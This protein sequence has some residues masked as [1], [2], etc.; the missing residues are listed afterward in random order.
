MFRF[1]L[2]IFFTFAFCAQVFSQADIT[3]RLYDKM[4]DSNPNDYIKT[5]VMLKDQVDLERLDKQLYEEKVLPA[6]RSQI[7]IR[8]L[9]DKAEKTQSQLIE[10]FTQKS[11]EGKVFSFRSFWIANMFAIEAKREVISELAANPDVELL[12][13]DDELD[14]DRPYDVSPANSDNSMASEPGLNIIKANQLW[15]LGYTGA[16][17]LVMHI[18][19]G[20]NINHAALSS[21]WRGNNGAQ[22]YHAWFD[23]ISPTSSLPF[24]CGSHGTHT[25][26]IMCGMVPGDT[27]GVAPDAQWIS[28][29]IT[30]CPGANYPSMNIAA[31]QWAMN[32]DSNISTTNDVPDVISC[33]WQDPNSN[34]QCSS[35]YVQTMN[36]LE[37]AGIG[38]VFS[39]GNSGPGA[40]TITPPKNIN[41]DEVNI[42]CVGNING[43]SYLGGNNNPIS[44]GSSRGPSTCGGVG[45]LLIKPE[46]VAPGTS[47]RSTIPTGYGNMSGTS[48]ASPHV[49]GAIALLKQVAPNL[50]GHQIKMALY[51]TAIDLGTV[52]EDNTYGKGLIDVYA[53]YQVILSQ[54]PVELSSFSA[55]VVRDEVHLNWSTASETNNSGFMIQKK[56]KSENEWSDRIF[57]TGAG[58]TTEQINY[59]FIDEEKNPGVYHYRLKQVDYD[60]TIEL[61]DLVEV[62]V[63]SPNKYSLLQNY[64][65]PFNP[66]TVIE[67]S[68]PEKAHVTLNIYNALGEFVRTL[69]NDDAE[70]GYY[71]AYF[72]AI[73][74]PSGLYV[75]QLT[76]VGET[77]TFTDSKKMML[78]K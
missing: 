35:I 3:T 41:T 32:P 29:G 45:S 63:F 4:F 73:D 8:A 1:T 34:P 14:W 52:G 61:S 54:I 23:P 9:M 37:T 30:D 48:M 66:T 25:M 40:S 16:G 74:L 44:S 11:N 62:E 65:N 18:D 47:I 60:G 7:V 12:D 28:A 51:N 57:I 17:R 72:N 13:L 6:E 67:F 36:A 5:L 68:L 39:A 2:L 71:R 58:T 15:A 26:G 59:S 56:L 19:T 46:V 50:T 43:T 76:A 78:V 55:N 21:K 64:P 38:V 77:S 69:A 24:D 53:A 20:V 75:Y 33:S 49:G 31:F 70:S 27:V 10:Y 42:M 22:W